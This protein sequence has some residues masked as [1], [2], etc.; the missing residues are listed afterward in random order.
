MTLNVTVL[1]PSIIY[2]SADFR[3]IDFDTANPITDRSAKTVMLTYWAW[4]G[5]ITYTGVGRWRDKDIS[6]LI[7]EWLTGV[8]EP[9]ISDVANTVAAKGTEMLRDVEQFFPR[10]RH[11]FTLAGFEKDQPHVYVISNFED[12]FGQSRNNIDDRLTVTTRS[13]RKGK[14]AIVIVTGRKEAVPLADRRMLGSVSGQYPED[15]LRVRRRMEALNRAA[16]S[17]PESGGAISEDCLVVSFRSDGT[18]AMQLNRDAVELPAQ[19][20]QISDGINVGEGMRD[21]LSN[22]GIDLSQMRMLQ[23]SFARG[24][25]ANGPAAAPIAP[26]RYA[27][28]TPDTSSGYHLSEITSADFEVLAAK[29]ISDRGQIIG[30]GRADAAAQSDIPWSWHGG[31]LERLNYVGTAVAVNGLGQI[32]ASPQL[33]PGAYRVAI[34]ERNTLVELPLYPGEPGTFV[35]VNSVAVAINDQM[36]IAGELHA[37]RED[38]RQRTATRAAIFN[39]SRPTVIFEGLAAQFDTRAVDINEQGRV[40][41]LASS[42]GSDV[43]CILW[44]PASGSWTYFDDERVYAF[45]VTLNDDDFALALSNNRY[46][47][48]VAIICEPG[49]NWK[50]LGTRDGWEPL[51][52]NNRGEVIG[53]GMIDGLFRP[54]LR[55]PTGEV[56]LL[57]YLSDHHTYLTSINNRGQIVGS[58]NADRCSHAIW[59]N[60]EV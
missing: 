58:A 1:T 49:G 57:P 59:W 56:V 11:T 24:R 31:P 35:G 44:D 53:R 60:I 48:P 33:T 5:F 37:D 19:F 21:A 51:D 7:A 15:S 26:C 42:S 8:G 25:P 13:L 17:L 39:P 12:C 47:H 10:R 18:G 50:R 55:R 3:L 29:D 20:P 43:H 14:K 23:G 27:I 9:S 28:R 45:P 52:M 6:D 38:P 32:V 40:L 2:Q 54:W 36:A 41:V 34:Y 4:D 16:A 22:V 30:T 46:G